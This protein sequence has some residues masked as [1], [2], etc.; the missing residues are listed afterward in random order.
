MMVVGLDSLVCWELDLLVCLVIDGF[1]STGIF[2]V[3]HKL[4]MNETAF[5]LGMNVT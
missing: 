2:L 3:Y 1:N 4:T 5:A